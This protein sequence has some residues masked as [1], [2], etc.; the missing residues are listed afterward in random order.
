[1]SRWNDS[2]YYGDAIELIRDI[3][4]K[5]V[6]MIQGRP[7]LAAN[8]VEKTAPKNSIILNPSY[9]APYAYKIFET[10]DPDRDWVGLAET[11]YEVARRSFESPLDKATS[12]HL[13][14]DWVMIDKATGELG[15]PNVENLRT[16][17]SYDALRLLWRFAVD[18]L[19]TKDARAKAVLDSIGL[20]EDEWR[21][22]G[23][24]AVSYSHDGKRLADKEALA[25]YGGILGLFIVNDPEVARDIYISK[26][27]DRYDTNESRW[28]FAESYYD[29]N[30]AWFGMALYA[31]EIRDLFSEPKL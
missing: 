31:G 8:N 9:F 28:R 11:S 6:V 12:A 20:L 15:A 30:W 4:S 2:T 29:E 14:P 13:P 10:V 24:V 5:E 21:K 22:N 7:Y 23:A 26:L 16:D 25:M 18:Y 19:W 17:F 1:M 3:W 27:E